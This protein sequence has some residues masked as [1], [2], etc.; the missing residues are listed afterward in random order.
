MKGKKIIIFPNHYHCSI[1]YSLQWLKKRMNE[2]QNVLAEGFSLHITSVYGKEPVVSD[3][4]SLV[5]D[6]RPGSAR[7]PHAPEQY[8]I[9][10]ESRQA[11]AS[12]LCFLCTTGR[13][14]NKKKV[15]NTCFTENNYNSKCWL[16]A[17]GVR[18]ENCL[19]TTVFLHHTTWHLLLLRM[20]KVLIF[21]F[22][23]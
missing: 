17:V 15:K 4:L 10:R 16:P 7:F 21:L 23:F 11:R 1:V 20:N 12:T 5:S 9:L 18:G 14:Y 19:L 3:H 2:G 13:D 22:F 6:L 8:K